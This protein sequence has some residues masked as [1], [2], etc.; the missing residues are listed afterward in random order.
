[1]G[2]QLDFFLLNLLQVTTSSSNGTRQSK[3]SRLEIEEDD[4]NKFFEIQMKFSSKKINKPD[5]IDSSTNIIA[6]ASYDA[7]SC[8]RESAAY[9]V[10]YTVHLLNF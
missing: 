3:T 4:N 6:A 9:Q 8:W 7:V 10:D 1:M 2:V 5:G